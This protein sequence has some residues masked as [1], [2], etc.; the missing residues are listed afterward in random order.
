MRGAGLR[1]A[2][3]RDAPP[4][5]VPAPSL[6]PPARCGVEAPLDDLDQ[7]RADVG[8]ELLVELAD[9][10]GARHVDLGDEAPDHIEADEHHAPGGHRRADLARQPAVAI[11]QRAADTLGA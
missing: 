2:R 5:P 9:A 11:S 6:A 10:G 8:A 3:A 1:A 7:Q 4:V